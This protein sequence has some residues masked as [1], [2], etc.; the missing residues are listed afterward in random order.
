MLFKGFDTICDLAALSNDPAG[1]LDLEQ[2]DG[3]HLE[4]Q[5][6]VEGRTL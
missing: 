1:R 6:L 2:T 4:G 3:H 5:D